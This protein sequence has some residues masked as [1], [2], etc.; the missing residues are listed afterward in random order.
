MQ[1]DAGDELQALLGAAGMTSFAA[2][3]SV[4]IWSI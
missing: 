2:I 4:R 1:P 3:S